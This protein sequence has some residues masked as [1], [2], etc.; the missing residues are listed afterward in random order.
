MGVAYKNFWSLNTDEAVVTG[1][2][3]HG[4][5]NDVG[6]YMPMDAQM[7]GIDLVALNVSNR[8]MVSIQVKGSRA[9]EPKLIELKRYGAGSCGWFFFPREVVEKASA[10]FFIFL[11][12]VIR[13]NNKTGRR[14]IEPHTIT[15]PTKKLQE[16][17]KANKKLHGSNRYS[18]YF[19]VNPD[20]CKSFDI[21]DINYDLSD[22]LD[23]KGIDRLSSMLDN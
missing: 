14:L 17:C 11:V 10:D 15:I 7:K 19:W 22:Y 4:L 2:L 1:I 21:R 3:K 12:Y 18:F 9:Y 5:K 6:V 20:T 13:E 8:K 23:S 16:F